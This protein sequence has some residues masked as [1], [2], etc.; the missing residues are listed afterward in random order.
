MNGNK[1]AKKTYCYCYY[2]YVDD[3]MYT[4]HIHGNH[5]GCD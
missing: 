1:P 3:F 5:L 2:C 4:H